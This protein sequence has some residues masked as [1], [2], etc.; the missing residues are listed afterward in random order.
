MLQRKRQLH[1]SM[2]KT[3]LK[4][5]A[6]AIFG[7]TLISCSNKGQSNNIDVW[8][9]GYNY[10]EVPI[11]A[12]AGYSMVMGWTLSI[13]INGDTCQ[14]LLEING[15]Q[16]YIKLLTNITGD[17]NAIAITY[18]NLIDGSDENLKKGDTLF[19][20]SRSADKLKTKWFAL[21]PRLLENPVKECN[22]FIRTRNSNR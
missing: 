5:L 6:S 16:T 18:N 10:D 7:L 14:G 21:E 4:L 13:N 2:Q 11:K 22:C 17:T 3:L 20:L 8:T 19:M 1:S 15:Q 12:I 9:G